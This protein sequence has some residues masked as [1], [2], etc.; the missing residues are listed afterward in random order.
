M[1]YFDFAH[2]TFA[3][4]HFF[5]LLLLLPVMLYW[6]YFSKRKKEN[7]FTV[8]SIHSLGKI[9]ET[10]KIKVRKFLP[11]LR[12]LAILFLII[13]LARPQSSN[14]N[15]TIHNEGIDIVL[16]MDISGSML[17]Q[18][19]KPNRIEAAKKVA[20]DFVINRPTDRIGLV[21]FSGESFTQ[22][23]LTTDQNTLLEQIKHVKSGLLED[24]TA[25]GM[26]LATAVERLRNSKAKSKIIILMT[27]GVNNTGLIDPITALEIAKAFKIRVY[28]IGIGTMGTAPYPIQDQ[29][30]NTTLQ[31]MPVQ[32]D[33][34]LM[35]KI[36][37]ETAGKYFR[38][39]DNKSLEK[40]YQEIDK[41]EKT[42]IE[43]NTFKRYVDLYFPYLIFGLCLLVT[44]QLLK[45]L[46]VKSIHD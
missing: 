40:I 3:Q 33:E 10:F 28:T 24:G 17:A 7:S 44:E 29:F 19:F 21:I 8:T 46:Y 34:A 37:K 31:Q 15:E 13:A 18:D 32:I 5:W 6:T 41:L 25:I 45:Y 16:S 9:N 27:D 26:G 23:P 11:I 20:S 38:A 1:N 12:V 4:P 30:G 14:I 22:C 35:Q 2:I 36:S 42:K 39:T 43:M